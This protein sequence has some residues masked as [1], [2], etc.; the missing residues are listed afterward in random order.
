MECAYGLDHCI[1]MYMDFPTAHSINENVLRKNTRH[2]YLT[3]L[4][5]LLFYLH[6][7]FLLIRG[8][9]RRVF[10]LE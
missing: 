7:Y 9:A 10:K 6:I 5:C 2:A 3:V 8:L 1:L 4:R